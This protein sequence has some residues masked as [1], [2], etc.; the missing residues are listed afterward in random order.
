M[1]FLKMSQLIIEDEKDL[2]CALSNIPVQF[3][4]FQPRV[5]C[6][7]ACHSTDYTRTQH[8]QSSLEKFSEDATIV[9]A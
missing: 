6:L 2:R 5:M 3:F 1:F 4:M 8:I 7:P 9:K